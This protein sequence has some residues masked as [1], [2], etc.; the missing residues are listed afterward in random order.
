M[1]I[2]IKRTPADEAFSRCVRERSNYVCERCGKV[3]DRSSMGLHCSHHFSRSNRCI[4]WCGENAMALCY[5]CH[6][7]YGGNP[8]D[9]GAWLR[10]KVPKAEEAE[11]AAHYRKELARMQA[12][13]KQGVTGRIEFE[14]WQ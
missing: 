11:I 14:S 13:R 2:G 6:A 5:A 3:Y 7:W 12:L 1:S 10:A 4:R 8:V 9:S